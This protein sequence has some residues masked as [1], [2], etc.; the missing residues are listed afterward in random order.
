MFAWID[1]GHPYDFARLAIDKGLIDEAG[2]A[3]GTANRQPSPIGLRAD[4]Y[5]THTFGPRSFAN[6][7]VLILE[8]QQPATLELSELLQQFPVE[9]DKQLELLTQS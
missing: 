5:G 6:Q 3:V 7:S 8:G 2:H 1:R 4:K 9:W